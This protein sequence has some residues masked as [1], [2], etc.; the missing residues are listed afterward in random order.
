MSAQWPVVCLILDLS[1]QEQ[2]P[3]GLVPLLNFSSDT[4]A[5]LHNALG[6]CFTVHFLYDC[7]RSVVGARGKLVDSHF[8][9]L[10]HRAVLQSL[11]TDNQV[12]LTFCYKLD[13]PAEPVETT[14][15]PS[16]ELVRSGNRG[17]SRS[18]SSGV[19]LRTGDAPSEFSQGTLA[20]LGLD[21]GPFSDMRFPKASK[22]NRQARMEKLLLET[23]H[24]GS[25]TLSSC[26]ATRRVCSK[27]SIRIKCASSD[28]TS[29]SK[30]R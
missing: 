29:S 1:A 20:R 17:S 14:F 4:C 23:G 3:R 9:V 25:L 24:A 28:T 19:S 16:T 15:I 30:G 8:E 27:L 6:P 11:L 22:A 12:S 13:K 10:D 18:S 5:R 26:F 2:Q 7:A 21:L